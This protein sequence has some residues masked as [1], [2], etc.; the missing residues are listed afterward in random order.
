MIGKAALH[1]AVGRDE[2]EAMAGVGELERHEADDLL[3]DPL[4]HRVREAVGRRGHPDVLHAADPKP[5]RLVGVAGDDKAEVVNCSSSSAGGA[6]HRRPALRP[7]TSEGGRSTRTSRV[8]IS[9]AMS[10]RR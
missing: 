5:A 1:E 4:L 10:T 6:M 3:A 2:L 7:W 9:V 8:A